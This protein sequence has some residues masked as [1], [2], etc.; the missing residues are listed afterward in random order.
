MNLTWMITRGSGLVAFALL[1][2]SAIWGLLLSTGVLGR[3]AKAKPLTWVHE[4]LAVAALLATFLHLV[5]LALDE[6]VEFGLREL[7][8]PGA[9]A[10]R[11]L[12]VAWGVV[13]FYGL[14]LITASFYV[15]RFIGQTAWR[16]LH[17]VSFGVLAGALV[18][19]ITAGTDTG[20]PA[21]IA[22]YAAATA[23]IVILV[24]VRAAGDSQPGPA[25]RAR[26]PRV[27]EASSR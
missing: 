9:S 19:G 11:P 17:Y 10:W 20:S 8:V 18:H 25:P 4:A 27:P 2:A 7:L 14:F 22:L 23:G 21:V 26:P 15:R 1:A 24:L 16:L 12:A 3:R 5:G 6:Y 13:A